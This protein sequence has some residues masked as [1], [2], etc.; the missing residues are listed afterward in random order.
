MPLFLDFI[1]R[2][3]WRTQIQFSA[4]VKN[5]LPWARHSHLPFL[6]LTSTHER[7]P[8]GPGLLTLCIL[9]SALFL[10]PLCFLVALPALAP[11]QVSRT[12]LR[13][14]WGLLRHCYSC[15]FTPCSTASS[16][17]EQLNIQT[18]ALMMLLE[19][20]MHTCNNHPSVFQNKTNQQIWFPH[21][22]L[23]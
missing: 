19:I 2:H 9:L 17:R 7:P 13:C 10:F 6:S 18:L 20:F 8:D 23:L 4:S 14:F 15:M 22:F 16:L 21:H 11:S 1:S 12:P 3:D 5:E